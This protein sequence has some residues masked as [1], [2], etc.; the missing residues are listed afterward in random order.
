MS[1]SL[2][3]KTQTNKS[4]Y[5]ASLA[6]PAAQNENLTKNT[7]VCVCVCAPAP[8]SLKL[9]RFQHTKVLFLCRFI[10]L[11]LRSTIRQRRS[12]RS[13]HVLARAPL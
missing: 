9:S 11:I 8:D 3:T 10:T 6:E 12:F 2:Q 5:T 1:D 13:Y 7:V 4:E